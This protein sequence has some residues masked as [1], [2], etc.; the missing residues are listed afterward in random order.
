MV[1]WR[2]VTLQGCWIHEIKSSLE[3][4]HARLRVMHLWPNNN[5]VKLVSFWWETTGSYNHPIIV[6]LQTMILSPYNF[7]LFRFDSKLCQ[8]KK[9]FNSSLTLILP[10]CS[11][12]STLPP[13]NAVISSHNLI[14]TMLTKHITHHL[15]LVCRLHLLISTTHSWGWRKHNQFSY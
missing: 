10:A 11:S 7:N 12:G 15:I 2:C 1:V 5:G 3:I 14:I 8:W 4:Y 13:H 9:C 6:N